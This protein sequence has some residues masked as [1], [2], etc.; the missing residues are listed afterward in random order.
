MAFEIERRFMIQGEGWKVFAKEM[1]K[2]H[3]AYLSTNFDEW[4]IR[5]RIINNKK[6]EL[7]FKKSSELMISHE[8][9][10][11]IPLQDALCLWDLSTKKLIK[12]RYILDFRPGDWV[13]D[14][15]MGDNYPLA[16]AEVEL[17]SKTEVIEK[18]SWCGEEITGI[19]KLSNA[20]LA[21]IPISDWSPKE[22]QY[23]NLK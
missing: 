15:F 5:T 9:E 12:H 1:Q 2:F 10:Y 23:F 8:F 6:S 11:P 19:K 3:Q 14:C 21:Q 16:L 13:V 18:P 7:T 17:S 20:S 22:L 4:I